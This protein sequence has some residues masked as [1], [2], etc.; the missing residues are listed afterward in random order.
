MKAYFVKEVQR[1]GLAWDRRL[2]QVKPS[3]QYRDWNDRT[4]IKL[5]FTDYLLV[6]ATT[7]EREQETIV[8][9][10]DEN[11]IPLDTNPLPGSLK[12]DR[13]HEAALRQAGYTICIADTEVDEPHIPTQIEDYDGAYVDLAEWEETTVYLTTDDDTTLAVHGVTHPK[14]GIMIWDKTRAADKASFLKTMLA[15]K[16]ETSAQATEGEVLCTIEEAKLMRAMEVRP[17]PPVRAP[18]AISTDGDDPITPDEEEEELTVY[19][20]KKSTEVVRTTK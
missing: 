16:A 2:Y 10:A 4:T 15:R 13:N 17:F 20:P 6:S 9:P 19:D 14:F 7:G 1:P 8:L 5:Q 3:F 12:N 11:G 18:S